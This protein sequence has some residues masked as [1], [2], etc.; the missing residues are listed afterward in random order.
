M[1]RR[2][3]L[4][5]IGVFGLLA[6]VAIGFAAPRAQAA[7]RSARPDLTVG[8]LKA[9]LQDPA[10]ETNDNFATSVA[11]SA[12]EAIVGSYETDADAGVAYIYKQA[13]LLVAD[14]AGTATLQDPGATS[15][16]DFGLSVSICRATA[17]VG[18]PGADCRFRGGLHLRRWRSSGWSASPTVTLPIRPHRPRTRSA[19]R[20][21]CRTAQRRRRRHGTGVGTAYVYTDDSFWLADGTLGHL[22][23]PGGQP[24]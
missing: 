20:Y 16:D 2:L 14:L 17:I 15:N 10:S 1:N 5:I 7:E 13:H 12:K 19:H 18:A 9:T 4:K 21:R 23:R 8:K 11:V 22:A 6:V 24:R 3:S